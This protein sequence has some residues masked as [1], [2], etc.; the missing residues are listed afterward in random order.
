MWKRLMYCTRY[1]CRIF[2]KLKIFSTDFRK[3]W[4]PNFIKIRQVGAELFHA[5][6]QMDMTKLTVAFRNFANAPKNCINLR[7]TLTSQFLHKICYYLLLKVVKMYYYNYYII[8]NRNTQRVCRQ[9]SSAYGFHNM[10]SLHTAGQ[11][12]DTEATN[13]TYPKHNRIYPKSHHNKF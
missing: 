1:S 7:C 4:I 2:V 6:G 11:Q 10:L 9:V 13:R 3:N 5:D 8:C 12:Y